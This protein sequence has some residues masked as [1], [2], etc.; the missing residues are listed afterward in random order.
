MNRDRTR[1]RRCASW[2]RAVLG[3][4]A[5]ALALSAC[6]DTMSPLHEAVLGGDTATVR[7]WAAQRKNLNGTFDEK[8]RGLEGNYAR[9]LRI[10]ALMLA[11]RSGQLDM[12][13]LLVDGGADLYAESNTQVPGEP[14]T[15]FDDAV[16][17]GRLEVVRFLWERS[18]RRRFG[19]RLDRQI[20][21]A[22][23]AMCN[24]A[25]G[26]DAD[27]NLALFLVSI[28][29]E[30]QRDWGIG[31]AVC[32]VD[33]ESPTARF[34]AAYVKPF[35][36]GT[37]ACVAY[38]TTARAVRTQA[39]RQAMVQWQIAQGADINHLG[40]YSTPLM[41]ASS[42]PDVEMVKFLLAQGADPNRL[43]PDG[44]TAIG[45][46]AGSCVMGGPT[47][48]VERL[49]QPQLEVIETL[50]RAGADTRLYTRELVQARLP[51]LGQC[52][53]RQPQPDAQQRI[54]RV[55]GLK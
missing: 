20:A 42:A 55:F 28:A 17:S 53:A 31:E 40:S 29:N 24:P 34:V 23:R 38:T 7:N 32:Y 41:G 48:E 10:T 33:P 11:A 2:A 6:G 44:T 36:K 16:E 3:L 14:H 43:G 22:C 25:S 39:Q 13:K 30:T 50:L 8:T 26:T 4:C 12:V 51:L 45:R 49:M 27:T 46:A 18:D 47:P 19:A 54:C 52:C 15:A 9:R 1:T 35:P 21:A 5:A 37:L